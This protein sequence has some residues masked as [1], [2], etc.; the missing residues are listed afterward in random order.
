MIINPRTNEAEAREAQALGTQTL[1]VTGT[2][3][4]LKTIEKMKRRTR[5]FGR[6]DI[7]VSGAA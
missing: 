6:V 5:A 2:A 4:E 1:V 3:G 7:Y